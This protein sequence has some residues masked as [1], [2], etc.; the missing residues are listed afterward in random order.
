MH[1]IGLIR[2]FYQKAQATNDPIQLIKAYT[3]ET[4]YYKILNERLAELH[5]S[6]ESDNWWGHQDLIDIM[7][8][9]PSLDRYT[10]IR[11]TYRGMRITQHDFK[12]YSVGT[13]LMNKAFLSTS[14]DR[15]VAEVFGDSCGIQDGKFSA[16]CMYEIRKPRSALDIET[17]SESE[18]EREVL[19]NPYILFQVK[20]VT[21][22]N[23]INKDTVFKIEL[24]E[25]D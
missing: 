2:S 19:L 24:R 12:L 17:I 4:Q 16:I 22:K 18:H 14:K 20:R 10:Y 5:E 9:H 11:T 3:A 8:S 1:G 21:R 23:T 13:L 7:L 6:R 15:A 25:C